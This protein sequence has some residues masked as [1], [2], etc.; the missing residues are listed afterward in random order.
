[1]IS[2]FQ[3]GK[4]SSCRDSVRCCGW[5]PKLRSNIWPPCSLYTKNTTK[6]MRL[7]RNRAGSFN[8]LTFFFQPAVL[9]KVLFPICYFPGMLTC[10]ICVWSM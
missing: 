6:R 4:F 5:V 8:I 9:V 1:M 3:G 7:F 10:Y 2:N